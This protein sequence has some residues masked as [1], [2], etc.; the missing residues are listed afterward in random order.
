ML[1]YIRKRTIDAGR[2]ETD[3]VNLEEFWLGR[4]DEPLLLN[5][6]SILQLL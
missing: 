5:Q 6:L 2:W 3:G 4:R 1:L